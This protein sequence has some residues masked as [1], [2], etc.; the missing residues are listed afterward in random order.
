MDDIR[1]KLDEETFQ[2]V[3]RYLPSNPTQRDVQL[4][5]IQRILS[6]ELEYPSIEA[7]LSIGAA[8]VM[9]VLVYRYPKLLDENESDIS[10]LGGAVILQQVGTVDV[11]LRK[12]AEPNTTVLGMSRSILETAMCIHN[13][14][15]CTF[16]ML[17]DRRTILP[18]TAVNAKVDATDEKTLA[19][20]MVQTRLVLFL[21]VYYGYKPRKLWLPRDLIRR[22]LPYV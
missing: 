16:R 13:D 1:A 9:A 20:R 3:K 19:L 17:R 5:R 6:Q 11:L 18:W 2:L 12:G 10:P 4:E 21:M 14:V 7:I 8:S 15:P 22:L